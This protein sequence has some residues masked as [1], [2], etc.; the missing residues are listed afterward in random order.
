YQALDQFAAVVA[1]QIAK[2]IDV[3]HVVSPTAQVIYRPVASNA[4]HKAL[5]APARVVPLASTP[6]F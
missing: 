3:D 2:V 6:K 5:E 4:E 1:N